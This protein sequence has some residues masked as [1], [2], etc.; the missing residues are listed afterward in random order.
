MTSD[1]LDLMLAVPFSSLKIIQQPHSSSSKAAAQPYTWDK[2]FKNQ[3]CFQKINKRPRGSTGSVTSKAV[4]SP[5]QNLEVVNHDGAAAWPEV[6]CAVL[7]SR[8]YLSIVSN[9]LTF[10]EIFFTKPC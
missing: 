4:C 8:T 10:Y 2:A 9:L 6:Y 3:S 5:E 7:P 1:S